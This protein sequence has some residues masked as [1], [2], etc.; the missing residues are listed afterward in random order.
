MFD[1]KNF[2]LSIR[3]LRERAGLSIETLAEKAGIEYTTLQRIE[4]LVDK[5]SYKTALALCN[6]LE[7]CFSDCLNDN[8]DYREIKKKQF[9]SRLQSLSD[10]Q[11]KYVLEIIKLTAPLRLEERELENG[12][13]ENK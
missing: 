3:E 13:E 8:I 10:I 11:K 5:P 4:T 9:E 2:A 1:Y 6:A 12:A 7:V